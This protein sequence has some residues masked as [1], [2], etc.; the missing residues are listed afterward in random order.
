MYSD[1]PNLIQKNS[2]GSFEYLVSFFYRSKRTRFLLGISIDGADSMKNIYNFYV[3]KSGFPNYWSKFRKLSN[4]SPA[5]PILLIFDNEQNSDRPLKQFLK[6]IG[7]KTLLG[8][9]YWCHLDKNIYIVT[10]PLV[11]GARECEIEDLF[12]KEVLAHKIGGKSFDR[13]STDNTKY[14]GKAIFSTYIAS[15]YM[16]IDFSQFKDFLESIDN[17]IKDY[18][19][20]VMKTL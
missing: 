8:S 19:I 9:S 10:C 15:N 12:T 13:K 11:N 18:R 17:A 16:N 7:N 3:G 1:Y 14:Y 20:N 6:Y 5:N 2:D 4:G